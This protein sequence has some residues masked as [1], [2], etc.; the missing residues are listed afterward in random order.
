M[1]IPGGGLHEYQELEEVRTLQRELRMKELVF[2][3]HF[4]RP[5]RAV[6]TSKKRKILIQQ[7]F[8]DWYVALEALLRPT[9]NAIFMS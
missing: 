3:A 7:I 5:N 2:C 8:G 4:I 6:F 1:V 9:R